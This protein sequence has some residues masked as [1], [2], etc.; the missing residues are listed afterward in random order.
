MPI[1]AVSG[2]WLI[3]AHLQMMK[4]RSEYDATLVVRS[5]ALRGTGCWSPPFSEMGG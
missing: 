5:R 3:A 1:A 2:S 4:T